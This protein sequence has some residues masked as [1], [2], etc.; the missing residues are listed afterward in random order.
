M[1]SDLAKLRDGMGSVYMHMIATFSQLTTVESRIRKLHLAFSF[2][3][4]CHQYTRSVL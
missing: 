2:S 1:V 4:V 3:L